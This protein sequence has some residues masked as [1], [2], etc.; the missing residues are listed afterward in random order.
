[1]NISMH[2]HNLTH[3]NY[4]CQREHR[5]ST[6]AK[7]LYGHTKHTFLIFNRKNNKCFCN[8]TFKLHALE[9]SFASAHRAKITDVWQIVC[10]EIHCL[11]L[12]PYSRATAT[13]KWI[14]KPHQSPPLQVLN[15]GIF[16]ELF[17]LKSKF[18]QSLAL[19][20]QSTIKSMT[21]TFFL[22]AV[23][24][25]YKLQTHNKVFFS[26]SFLRGGFKSNP[27]FQLL[28]LMYDPIMLFPALLP[29][30][31]LWCFH[32]IWLRPQASVK[33]VF[34]CG[35]NCGPIHVKPQTY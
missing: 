9:I 30:F 18:P 35:L 20:R 26:P 21:Q 12:K 8:S 28:H 4:L 19:Q 17:L 33:S 14:F 23:T 13:S 27:T 10:Q 3:S 29:C 34:S 31:M 5:T 2:V 1:M 6:D 11:E 7:P 15:L 16:T 24:H 25:F 32:Y 22:I